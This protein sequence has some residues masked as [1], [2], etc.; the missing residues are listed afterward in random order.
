MLVA[1]HN[2]SCK[3]LNKELVFISCRSADPLCCCRET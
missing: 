3:L 1:D 2:H